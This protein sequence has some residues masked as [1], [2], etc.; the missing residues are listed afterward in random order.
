MKGFS[1]LLLSRLDKNCVIN[2]PYLASEPVSAALLVQFHA[3]LSEIHPDSV[4]CVHSTKVVDNKIVATIHTKFTACNTIYDSVARERKDPLLQPMFGVQR[5]ASLIRNINMED[6]PEEEKNQF[7]HC[8]N[9]TREDLV[10]YVRFELGLTVN[11]VSKKVTRYE[12]IGHVTSVH[13]SEW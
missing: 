11:D 1:R 8:V 5:S 12:L 9:S 6:R 7:I 10:F 2:V 4:A 3:L 13:P